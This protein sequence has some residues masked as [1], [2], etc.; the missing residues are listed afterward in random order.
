[1]D[2]GLRTRSF[3]TK[4]IDFGVQCA[5]APGVFLVHLL[6]LATFHINFSK[7]N[8]GL[9]WISDAAKLFTKAFSPALEVCTRRVLSNVNML[10]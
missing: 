10:L 2:K 8:F 6:I 4:I 7:L 1:M 3:G 9:G 5:S